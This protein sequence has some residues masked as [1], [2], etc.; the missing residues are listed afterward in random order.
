MFWRFSLLLVAG[1][2]AAQPK[3]FGFG[4]PVSPR[5]AQKRDLTVFAD[6][7]GLPP[8]RGT[9]AQGAPIYAAKCAEC[10]ND[11]GEGREKQ[12]PGLV[13]GIGSLGTPKP[14][15]SVGSYWPYA[16]TLWDHIHRAMPFDH[17]RTLTADE[18]YAVTAFV[19]H[20]NG[21]VTETQELNEKTLPKVVMP[22]RNGFIPPK[23]P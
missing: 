10:H 11:R 17:P 16:T 5:E 13:G 6:G 15:K 14:K 9:A 8:G 12:Y 19:L 18:T 7:Q 3:P 23:R 20:L 1:L 22:N 2:L 21:I 4:K